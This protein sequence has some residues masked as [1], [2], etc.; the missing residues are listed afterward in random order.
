RV[1]QSFVTPLTHDDNDLLAALPG[2]RRRPGVATK[3]VVI[4]FCDSFWCFG[5]HRGGD[6]SSGPW[7]GKKDGGVTM[8]R[9]FT[10]GI[11]W[12][13]Q[14]A[15]QSLDPLSDFGSLLAQQAEPGKQKQGSLAG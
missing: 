3:C 13:A 7:Q 1:A 2:D 5:E 9:C 14:L 6:L 4:S 15:K 10:G 8:L 11:R 12:G